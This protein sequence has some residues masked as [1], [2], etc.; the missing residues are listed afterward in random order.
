MFPIIIPII[1]LFVPLKVV[2]PYGPTEVTHHFECLET[3]TILSIVPLPVRQKMELTGRRAGW[4][5]LSER[6]VRAEGRGARTSA[7]LALLIRLCILCWIGSQRT[8]RVFFSDPLSAW[9]AGDALAACRPILQH[10]R[11]V[12][13]STRGH[14]QHLVAKIQMIA[15]FFLTHIPTLVDPCTHFI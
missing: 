14:V 13:N 4:A 6:L 10:H 7:L 11:A 9:Q 15:S 2:T 5:K 3:C 1:R 12:T 8:R